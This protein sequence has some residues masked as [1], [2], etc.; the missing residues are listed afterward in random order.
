MISHNGKV[1]EKEHIYCESLK[2]IYM[3]IY[4]HMCV[5]IY[6]YRERE[7]DREIDRDIY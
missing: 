4:I 2:N 6:I 7:R 3:F 1:Y 5:C